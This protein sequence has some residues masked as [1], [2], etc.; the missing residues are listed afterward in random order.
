MNFAEIIFITLGATGVW[1]IVMVLF[2]GLEKLS[3]RQ[4][5][6]A[7][8]LR[9]QQAEREAHGE[10]VEELTLPERI[11]KS[12]SDLTQ[13]APG[14]Q[15][16]PLMTQLMRAGMPF[17]SPQHFYN[18]Q[19]L[20][21]IGMTVF[22]ILAGT[23]FSLF[24]NLTPWLILMLGL[25]LGI[26]GATLPGQEVRKKTIR[27]KEGLKIDMTFHLP[28]LRM[29][30]RN[31][32]EISLAMKDVIASSPQEIPFSQNEQEEMR[33]RWDTLPQETAIELSMYLS[34]IGGNYFS[35]LLTRFSTELGR[36]VSPEEA[37]EKMN[38]YFEPFFF[39][40]H[41]LSLLVQGINGRPIAKL[42]ADLDLH[43]HR[44][45]KKTIRQ[46]GAD[47][48]TKMAFASMLALIPIFIVIL[49]PLVVIAMSFLGG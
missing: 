33:K 48:E 14:R 44:D 25:A 37:A 12:V 13:S 49:V 39:M 28:R 9:V 21:A 41:F 2:G 27:R 19:V 18:R 10:R 6:D 15:E 5:V 7:I 4:K 22:G 47:A 43:L 26:Y 30:L 1:I 36:G 24:F 3:K 20:Y 35:E 17:F 23:L 46:K 45:L 16:T 29:G 38:R 40:D 32:G 34:G 31:I 42:L 8:T 11:A